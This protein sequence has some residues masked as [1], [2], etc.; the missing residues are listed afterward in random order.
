MT[1]GARFDYTTLE[2]LENKVKNNQPS[3]FARTKTT[4]QA[5]TYALL[6]PYY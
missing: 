1:D 6:V 5:N 2:N 4:R 3:V